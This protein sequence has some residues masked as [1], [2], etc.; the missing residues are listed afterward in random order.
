MRY[1]PFHTACRGESF[2]QK[3][4]FRFDSTGGPNLVTP[5]STIDTWM[6][7]VRALL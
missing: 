5:Q 7:E 2:A 3:R 6:D 4:E 1:T